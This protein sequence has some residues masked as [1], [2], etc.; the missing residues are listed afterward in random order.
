[1]LQHWRS[2]AFSGPRPFYYQ[3]EAV[4][5]AIW[6]AEVAR[7]NKQYA[8]IFRHL[9]EANHD[10]NPEIFRLALKLATGAGKTTVMA[11]L[12]AWQAINAARLRVLKPSDGNSFVCVVWSAFS[13]TA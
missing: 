6:L 2:D 5:T 11:M 7:K 13:L 1:M 3:V 8:H 12:V 9:E 4:E 10:T